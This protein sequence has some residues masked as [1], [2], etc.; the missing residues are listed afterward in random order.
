MQEIF[1]SYQRTLAEALGAV[2]VARVDGLADALEEARALRRQVFLCG[3]GGS[4]ANAAHWA[5]DL[6]YGAN[7]HGRGG[8]RASALP[9]NAS[10][11]TCLAN[12]VAYAEVFACQLRVLGESGDVLIVLSGSGNSPNILRALEEARTLGISS[13]A[14]LGFDGGQARAL[15]DHAIHF[16]VRDMQV[17]EDCQMALA[18]AVSRKLAGMPQP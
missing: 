14:I 15:A 5:N 18:H 10:V 7:A 9:A 11:L 6:I 4:A 13:W 2:D 1:E 3:N 12:D 17:A 16:P 8:L